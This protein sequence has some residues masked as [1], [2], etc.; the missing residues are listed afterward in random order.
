MAEKK[1]QIIAIIGPTGVGKTALS[2]ELA[3]VLDGEIISGDSIQVYRGLDIGSAKVTK[4]EQQGIPHY[5]IDEYDYTQD[6]NVKLFQQRCRET[7]AQIQAKGKQPI[8]CG[9]TGLYIKAALYDYVFLDELQDET[10]QRFLESLSNDELY[11]ALSIIDAPACQ[12]IHKNNRRRLIRA[13]MIAHSG[14]KKSEIINEQAHQPLY[15][16]FLIGLTMPREQLYARIDQRVDQMM[17]NGLLQE[18]TQLAQEESIWSSAGFKGIGYKEWYAY[19]H[20]TSDK[21]TCIDQIKKNSRNFAKRQYTWFRNQ[22][23]VHWY[24]ISDPDWKQQIQLDLAE[25]RK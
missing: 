21:E 2:I 5:L 10:H 16:L 6:Y 23:P 18:V 7:I 19:F 15:D 25:W 9:G 20:G 17:E 14:K 3:K 8:I 22:L 1:E 13:L 12:Q 4:E 24:D 11:A